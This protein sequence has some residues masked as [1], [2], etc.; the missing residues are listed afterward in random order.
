MRGAAISF[1]ALLAVA[2]AKQQSFIQLPNE[3]DFVALIALDAS[4]A[5]IGATPLETYD[6]NDPPAYAVDPDTTLYFVGWSR[7]QLGSIAAKVVSTQ[8]LEAASGC[9][10]HLPAPLYY[11]KIDGDR[12]S[13][14]DGTSAPPLGAPWLDGACDP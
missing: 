12:L 13:A 4:G 14:V 5:L 7:D 8:R 1:C 6:P 9:R 11:A 3:I 2:C 10:N